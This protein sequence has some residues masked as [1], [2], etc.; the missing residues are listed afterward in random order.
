M[1]RLLTSGLIA[2]AC[3]VIC[4]IAGVYAPVWVQWVVII[5]TAGVYGWYGHDFTYAVICAVK[6]WRARRAA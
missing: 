2:G 5:P 6:E 1:K 3:I 4:Y